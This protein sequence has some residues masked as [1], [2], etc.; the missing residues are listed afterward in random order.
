MWTVGGHSNLPIM[1]AWIGRDRDPQSKLSSKD[2]IIG[3]LWVWLINPSSVNTAE[4]Q[5]RMI[6]RINL[7]YSHAG[8][9]RYLHINHVI[10]VQS[11]EHKSSPNLKRTQWCGTTLLIKVQVLH[12][13]IASGLCAI[14]RLPP[15]AGLLLW[16]YL[17]N[18]KP[19][20]SFYLRNVV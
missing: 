20:H 13:Q 1:P 5:S 6:P 8:V 12:D 19:P 16:P 4:E 14:G 11:L 17:G 2:D 7:W 15:L 9:Q 10:T 3:K 18:S